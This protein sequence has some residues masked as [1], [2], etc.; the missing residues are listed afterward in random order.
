MMKQDSVE[1]NVFHYTSLVVAYAKRNM[2]CTGSFSLLSMA[3][4]VTHVAEFAQC[5]GHQTEFNLYNILFFCI[6]VPYSHS[7]TR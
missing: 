4:R 2:V 6:S 7:A 5:V 1:P 3:G